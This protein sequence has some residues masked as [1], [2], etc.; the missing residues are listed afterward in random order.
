MAE[1]LDNSV[2]AAATQVGGG[3]VYQQVA[4][5]LGLAV[6]SAASHL[7]QMLALETVVM[8]KIAEMLLASE[9]ASPT[10]QTVA[11][12]TTLLNTAVAN[13]IANITQ[14][15][16]ASESVLQDFKSAL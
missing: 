12:L 15:G 10:S 8:A 11:D 5:S 6:Q 16:T 3:I 14:I 2:I 9:G 13:S 1:P 4:Q 7:E